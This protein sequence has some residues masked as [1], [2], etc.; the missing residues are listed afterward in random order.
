M[1]NETQ[2]S[3]LSEAIIQAQSE[4]FSKI[5]PSV[6]DNQTLSNLNFKT[7][8]SLDL[9]L[10]RGLLATLN[11]TKFLDYFNNLIENA[12]LFAKNVPYFMSIH[13]TDRITLLKSSVFEII[14]VRHATCY[15][16]SY[17]TQ[18]NDSTKSMDLVTLAAVAT[19]S[20]S[21][22]TFAT[23]NQL[24]AHGSKSS[25]SKIFSSGSSSQQFKSD[26]LW[27]PSVG[28]WTSC[29]W[30]GER[31]P[32]LKKFMQMLIEFYR[33]FSIVD[34]TDSE[35]AIFCSYLLYKSGRMLFFFRF[36][37]SYRL[38]IIQYFC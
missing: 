13:E 32:Q 28:S 5:T 6:L 10:Q 31:M 27:V 11:E 33:F 25:I 2:L 23:V 16:N 36:G 18:L 24:N 26:F 21:P 34:L 7:D 15:S 4:T 37:S 38:K 8:P 9:I 14:V 35:L 20:R 3:N 1:L 19:A 22:S 29:Q 12:V 30:L 17:Y